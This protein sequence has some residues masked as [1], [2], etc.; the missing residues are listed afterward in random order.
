VAESLVCGTLLMI[1]LVC[2][3]RLLGQLIYRQK[4]RRITDLDS[5]NGGYKI[6]I[7]QEY[8]ATTVDFISI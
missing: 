7:L 6:I 5:Y 3:F 1:L 4:K 8:H 2:G